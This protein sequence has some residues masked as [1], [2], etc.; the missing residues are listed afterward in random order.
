MTPHIVRNSHC[1]SSILVVVPT[2]LRG[3]ALLLLLLVLGCAKSENTQ[4]VTYKGRTFRL[5]IARNRTGDYYGYAKE[6]RLKG[7]GAF[8]YVLLQ[9]QETTDGSPG[10]DGIRFDP[11]SGMV[12]YVR[13][14]KVGLA[15]LGNSA[16]HVVVEDSKHERYV[17]NEN[18]GKDSTTIEGVSSRKSLQGRVGG[19][20][21]VRQNH[22]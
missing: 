22:H 13:G 21:S 9:E 14:H 3:A 16:A 15:Y 11:D 17:E 1:Q 6:I 8:S 4:I 7:P 10:Q 2:R 5:W 12:T 18:K 20:I 19:K